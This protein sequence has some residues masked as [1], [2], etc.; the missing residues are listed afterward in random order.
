MANSLIW[1]ISDLSK[2]WL[3]SPFVSFSAAVAKLF[4]LVIMS[5]LPKDLSAPL[6]TFSDWWR[7]LGFEW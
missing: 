2:F 1:H 3:E 4:E 7:K 6:V 5:R